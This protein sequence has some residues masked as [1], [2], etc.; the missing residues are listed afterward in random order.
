[1]PARVPPPARLASPSP[2]GHPRQLRTVDKEEELRWREAKDKAREYIGGKPRKAVPT[3][4]QYIFP[5]PFHLLLA[6]V[7]SFVD[8]WPNNDLKHIYEG[9]FKLASQQDDAVFRFFL[10][11]TF[12]DTGLER[13]YLMQSVPAPHPPRAWRGVAA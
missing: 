5:A 1:M 4:P 3:P 11:S 9:Y 12:S 13:N 7:R 6:D 8:N 2:R 10:S